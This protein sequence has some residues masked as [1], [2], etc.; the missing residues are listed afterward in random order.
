MPEDSGMM[1]L[2]ELILAGTIGAVLGVFLS[3]GT[4]MD[5]NFFMKVLVIDLVLAIIFFILTKISTP[6]N[7]ASATVQPYRER[8]IPRE[9]GYGGQE[10]YPEEEI[11]PEEE[12]MPE[13]E[14]EPIPEEEWQEKPQKKPAGRMYG[15][16][17]GKK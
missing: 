15:P 12:Q 6:K 16:K 3:A 2:A 14:E 1:R 4:P 5:F 7:R 9:Q 11:A 8:R 17:K 13:E 10:S